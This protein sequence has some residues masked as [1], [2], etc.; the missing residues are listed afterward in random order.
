[1]PRKYPFPAPKGERRRMCD[2]CGIFW[3]QSTMV[4]DPA[5]YWACP[6]DQSGKDVVTLD[7]MNNAERTGGGVPINGT[8]RVI[9]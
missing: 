1:M 9:S 8:V 3:Y 2:Y 6:D 7:R 5:G 4:L